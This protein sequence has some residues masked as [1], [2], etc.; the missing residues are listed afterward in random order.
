M[1]SKIVDTGMLKMTTFTKRQLPH[2]MFAK[3]IMDF[4]NMNLVIS[5]AKI[6]MEVLQVGIT[7][8]V[9]SLM[10]K[11]SQAIVRLVGIPTTRLTVRLLIS[12]TLF[13][14]EILRIS[15]KKL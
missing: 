10:M 13:L 4:G 2:V 7:A 8:I 15:A 5:H 3:P 1:N 6:A 14:E 12:Y 9:V 11:A